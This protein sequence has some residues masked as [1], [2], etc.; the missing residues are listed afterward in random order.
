[1]FLSEKKLLT[2]FLVLYVFTFQAK[3]QLFDD[4][5]DGNFTENPEWI[6]DDTLFQINSDLQLQLN[7]TTAG[8]ACLST[9]NQRITD[10]EWQF[11]IKIDFSP[12]SAS[13]ARVYLSSDIQNL[14]NPLNGYFLQF[15]ESGNTDAIELFRQNGTATTSICRSEDGIIATKFAIRVKVV[16]SDG[17]TWNVYA[18]MNGGNNFQFLATGADVPS[19]NSEYFGVY[20]KYA[21]SYSTKIWFDNFYIGTEIFD[22]EPPK[23]TKISVPSSSTVQ[24]TFDEN[25]TTESAQNI[26]NYIITPENIVPIQATLLESNQDVLLTFNQPFTVNHT[27]TLTINGIEDYSGNIANNLSETFAWF[28]LQ[29]HDVI[30]N[31]IMADPSPVV[32]LPDWEYIEL[33]NRTDFSI[34]LKDFIL[35]IGTSNKTFPEVFIEPQDYLILCKDDAST[36]FSEYGNT[37]GFSSFSLT[38]SGQAIILRNNQGIIITQVTYSDTWYKD[39]LKKNGGWSLELIDP[40]NFCETSFNW[41]A[42]VNSNGGTPGSI[43]SVF[44]ENIDNEP[45]LIL[46]AEYLNEHRITVVFSKS[47]DA[48]TVSVSN[49]WNVNNDLTI[50]GIFPVEPDYI[51]AQILFIQEIQPNIIYTLKTTNDNILDCSGSYIEAGSEIFFATPDLIDKNDIIIN[52]ILHNAQIGGA[53]YIELYNRSD[54]TLDTKDLRLIFEKSSGETSEY[55]IPSFLMLPQS[56][57]VLSKNPEAVKSQYYIPNPE[58]FITVESFPTLTVS[59]GII[60]IAKVEDATQVIDAMQYNEK[61]HDALLNSV[62]GVSLERINPERPSGDKTNW[63]SAA[64][65]AGFGTPGYKNSQF[66]D[67]TVED[68]ISIDPEIFTPNNDGFDDYLNIRYQFDESGYIMNVYIFDARGIKIRHLINN[69]SVGTLGA[70]SWDGKNESGQLSNAGIYIIYI[71]IFDLKGNVK[72]YKKTGTLGVKF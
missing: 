23:I 42:S 46:R 15:G 12:S 43:N 64:E 1:M 59:E 25:I 8:S 36:L 14:H 27:Y 71:E 5:S 37:L 6:G 54:K 70:F 18:D 2:L 60:R 33:F 52:E 45:P 21:A 19:M 69:E 62:K 72:R 10:T 68:L 49:N 9:V 35:T 48:S 56:F 16:Y 11:W 22:M 47:M 61:M 65:L 20:C 34:N 57:C 3:A 28:V 67:G 24:I 41:T 30:I 40:E 17:G 26:A 51:S 58:N 29:S 31:E 63:H 13:F 4:F 44:G 55:T 66:D 32:G 50:A 39:D 38:N 7:A 53:Q